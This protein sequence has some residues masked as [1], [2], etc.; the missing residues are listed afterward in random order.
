MRTPGAP[1]LL[2]AAVIVA[3]PLAGIHSG[4]WLHSA[5]DSLATVA[6]D[7]ARPTSAAIGSRPL[8]AAQT[9]SVVV[10]LRP[11]NLTSLERYDAALISPKDPAFR[12]YLTEPEYLAR[13]APSHA[14]VA[15]VENYLA[16]FGIRNVTVAVDRSGLTVVAPASQLSA[17]LHTSFVVPGASGASPTYFAVRAP[18][19]PL[20]IASVVFGIGG[21]SGVRAGDLGLQ[22]SRL[23]PHP[24]RVVV[25]V[26]RFVSDS[27][28][29]GEQWFL[30]S[31][32]AQLYGTSKLFPGSGSVPN[33][34]FA[35][36]EAVATLLM[37]GYNDSTKQDLPP[38]D[39]VAVESYFNDT[40]PSTWPH[41]NVT[42]VPVTVAGRTP[43]LPGFYQG[44][45][46]TTLTE[47]ENSLDLEMA[48][49]EAPGAQVV[50]F[51]FASSL[52]A[53][54]SAAPS[55]AIADD[56]ALTLSA[57]LD[58]NY[59][60]RHLAAVSCSFGLTDLNDSLWDTQLLHAAALGVTVVAA[61]GDQG[62]APNFLSGRNQGA[63]PSWPATAA[64]NTSGTLAVGGV[65]VSAAGAGY[66]V[67]DGTN[68]T[69]G[70]DSNMTG[71][72]SQVAW[73]DTRGGLGAISGTEGG[74]SVAIHEPWWQFHS[75]AQ[76]RIVDA[77][78]AQGANALGRAE[79]DLALPANATIAYVARD[80]SGVYF[81][82]LEGTSV[83]A[84]TYAGMLAAA[85]A[86]AGHPFGFVDPE[87]Y[88][89][90]GYFAASSAN[91]TPFTA[92]TSGSNWVFSAGAGWD[93]LT[94]WGTPTMPAFLAADANPAIRNYTYTGPT[95]VLPPRPPLPFTQSGG[96]LPPI[97]LGAAVLVAAIVVLLVVRSPKDAGAVRPV[98]PGAS[99]YTSTLPPPPPG[100]VPPGTWMFDC[101]YCGRL[102]PA[103]PVPCPACGRL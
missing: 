10:A 39:P 58:H 60:P 13:Y 34:T 98:P 73:Y 11:A 40:F 4:P 72:A 77:A 30:G 46:D 62:N 91:G 71:I 78:T 64:F 2:L 45:N 1:A 7:W 38:F 49:S 27:S 43:P 59:S 21:M 61:S 99:G 25:P 35:A 6:S 90:A 29:N 67:F 57:A 65:T 3:V 17:A 56:F 50:N 36:N 82:V 89:M 69:E 95:P 92:V 80:T 83:G 8:P 84:P 54:S 18:S 76:P 19:V 68:L 32:F 74:V 9:L 5:S 55:G 94:G 96:L 101:P 33:A 37:S 24:V 26:D 42:G 93:A 79:P 103:D 41:P 86:V 31:D 44:L 48:G 88:R 85:A 20:P 52:Y 97:V 66:G 22:A 23:L 28:T 81:D 102:R 16:G 47:E 53:T 15:L 70:F 12:Q 75:A 51:Y 87:L 14:T 100:A 63:W